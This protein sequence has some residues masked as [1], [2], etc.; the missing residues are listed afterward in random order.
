MRR[1]GVMPRRSPS[2]ADQPAR[3]ASL[4]SAASALHPRESVGVDARSGGILRTGVGPKLSCFADHGD[5][6]IAVRSRRLNRRLG[7]VLD[8][9]FDL[10]GPIFRMK[11]NDQ[12][13]GHVDPG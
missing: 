4:S 10:A 8:T 3:A 13:K 6:P 11:P 2:L 9:P 7:L 12:V 1:S 5:G